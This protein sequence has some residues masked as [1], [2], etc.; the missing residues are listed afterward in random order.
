MV[1]RDIHSTYSASHHRKSIS[2]RTKINIEVDMKAKYI[3]K[4]V[5]AHTTMQA[6]IERVNTAIAEFKR[7]RWSY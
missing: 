3:E 7:G 5:G 6:H 2:N 1:H 4:I